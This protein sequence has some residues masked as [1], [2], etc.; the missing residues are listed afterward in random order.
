MAI[1]EQPCRRYR[2]RLKGQKHYISIGDSFMMFHAPNEGDPNNSFEYSLI[3]AICRLASRSRNYGMTWGEVAYQI[4]AAT[5]GYCP[6]NE[7]IKKVIQQEILRTLPIE[8]EDW[9]E[10]CEDD[11]E[12]LEVRDGNNTDTTGV[13]A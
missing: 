7:E 5:V 9:V 2:I 13:S 12:M 4:G 1:D 3:N 8:K 10:P 6:I 11:C